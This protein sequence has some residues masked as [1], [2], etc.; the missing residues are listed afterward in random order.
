MSHCTWQSEQVWGKIF[1]GSA[2]K[3]L[4]MVGVGVFLGAL[5]L[6][7]ETEA[8]AADLGNLDEADSLLVS[9]EG[10]DLGPLLL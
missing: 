5:L 7:L 6:E 3:S 2:T 4:I 8:D 9:D 1:G 10:L